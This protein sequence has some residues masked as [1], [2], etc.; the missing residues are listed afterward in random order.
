MNEL[1][2]LYGTA[3]SLGFFHTILGP[4]H[5]VPFIVLSKARNWS[6]SKTLWITFISGVGHVSSSVLLGF[7]GVA[8]GISINKLE[9]I[10]AFRGEIVGWMLFAFG[11]IYFFYGIYRYMKGSGHSHFF[12][13]LLPAKA[14][15]LHHLPTDENEMKEKNKGG[16]YIVDAFSDICFR[17]VRSAYSHIDFPGRRAQHYWNCNGGNHLRPGNGS[18]HAGHRLFRL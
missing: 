16:Y 4:D 3:A 2:L 11:M 5:Y 15:E 6:K 1:Y 13:F 17:S 18:Y 7:L 10:E 14:R 12:H 8:L 9:S